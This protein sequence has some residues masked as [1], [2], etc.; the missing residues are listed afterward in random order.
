MDRGTRGLRF[1][2]FST[3]SWPPPSPVENLLIS[4]VSC[5]KIPDL[6]PFCDQMRTN[7]RG[8]YIQNRIS[9]K[10]SSVVAPSAIGRNAGCKASNT[11]R[12]RWVVS[13]RG[14]EQEHVS[15]PDLGEDGGAA[16]RIQRS[17]PRAD[18]G[19][20][21]RCRRRGGDLW[22]IR[23]DHSRSNQPPPDGRGGAPFTHSSPKTA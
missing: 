17:Q 23:H 1:A 14:Q 13:A 5:E 15:E 11:A 20:R 21:L 2:C 9:Q 18:A 10:I 12:P 22:G 19:C 3:F 8:R 7:T 16:K 4:S 6:L